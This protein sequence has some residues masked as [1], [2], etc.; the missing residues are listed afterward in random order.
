MWDRG[1]VAVR[2]LARLK[3]AGRL[4]LCRRRQR[5]P[6]AVRDTCGST[7][8]SPMLVAHQQAPLAQS[9][10][11]LHGKEKVYGSIP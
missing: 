3:P 1:A 7:L 6:N 11:R 2:E 10:E 4:P 8:S 5:D 9:A